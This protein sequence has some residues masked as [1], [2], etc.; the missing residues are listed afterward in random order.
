MAKC[1]YCGESYNPSDSKTDSP[2]CS[3]GCRECH[4]DCE[5]ER[6]SFRGHEAEYDAAYISDY[7]Y[8][9]DDGY[10]FDDSLDCEK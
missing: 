6:G 3:F 8:F 1:K 10:H 4:A 5:F 9:G 2:F 7:E